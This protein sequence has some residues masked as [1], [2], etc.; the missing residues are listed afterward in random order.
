QK[1]AYLALFSKQTDFTLSLQ[2]QSPPNDSQALDLA[3]TTL[4]RRKGRGLDVMTDTIAMLRRYAAPEDQTLLAQLAEAR[5]QLAALTLKESGGDKPDSYRAQLKLLE[6][7]VEKLEAD[8]SFRIDK[9]RAQTQPVTL[10][11]I[12][13]A[14]PTG[15]TLVEFA[16]YT[17]QELQTGNNKPP[18]YLAYMLAAQGQPKWVDLGEAAMI[19]SAVDA[20]RIA[21]R[22]PNRP[23]QEDVKRLARAVDEKV[24]RPVRSLLVNTRQLLLAP[25]GL[26]NL[27]PFAA[28]VDEQNQYLVQRYTISYLTSG[29]DLLRLQTSQQN[30]SAPLVLANPVFGRVA[31][32]AARAGQNFGSSKVGKQGWAQIDPKEIFFQPL[33]GT[34]H[35]AQAIKALVPEASVLLRE[36]ATETAL[37]QA[38]APRILHIATHGFFLS[39]QEAPPVGTRGFS[40]DNT[41]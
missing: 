27:I 7:K 24:M 6:D 41:L 2:S 14:L 23:N 13:A 1:L 28:L 17:P 10:A 26:L 31:T 34:R 8:L 3:F 39:D 11:A 33:P 16:V 22:D 36:Q 40:S 37:K 15:S 30:N 21:L 35:E 20:W 4:L 9:F 12:Q 38:R 25:D 18:R 5:S 19:D 32:V 29:R